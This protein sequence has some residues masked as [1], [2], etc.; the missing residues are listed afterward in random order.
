MKSHVPLPRK[1]LACDPQLLAAPLPIVARISYRLDVAFLDN[2]EN[3]YDHHLRK[4][5][6]CLLAIIAI[7]ADPIKITV[8]ARARA[9]QTEVTDIKDIITIGTVIIITVTETTVMIAIGIRNQPLQYLWCFLSR[10]ESFR[11]GI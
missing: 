6:Q 5:T 11:K 9:P 10:R 8:P 4:S 7:G 1:S 3:G 2:R